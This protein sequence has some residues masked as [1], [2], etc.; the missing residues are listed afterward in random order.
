MATNVKSPAVLAARSN[1]TRPVLMFHQRDLSV[2]LNFV[3]CAGVLVMRNSAHT[4]QVWDGMAWTTCNKAGWA[5]KFD[6]P[7]PDDLPAGHWGVY[8]PL[9]K[10]RSQHFYQMK[11]DAPEL[12]WALSVPGPVPDQKRENPKTVRERV[13]EGLEA[14]FA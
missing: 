9:K 7:F 5:I 6:A 8:G 10:R 11:I 14:L 3:R 13:T 2:P 12:A 1:R 4:A